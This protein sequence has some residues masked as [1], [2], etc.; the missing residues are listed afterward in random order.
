M[1]WEKFSLQGRSQATSRSNSNTTSDPQSCR[2]G[3]PR[4]GSY[5]T[6]SVAGREL[7]STKN[8][9]DPLLMSMFRARD[10]R[11]RKEGAT[12]AIAKAY[13][14]EAEVEDIDSVTIV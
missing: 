2:Q 1:M 8:G 13:S 5:A 10:K 6:F 14:R 12:E 11:V 3:C 4:M 9:I 7:F